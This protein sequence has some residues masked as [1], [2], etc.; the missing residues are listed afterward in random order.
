MSSDVN[1]ALTTFILEADELLSETEQLLIDNE[2][3]ANYGQIDWLHEVFRAVHTIKGSAGLFGLDDLVDFSHLLESLL[4]RL[5]ELDIEVDSTIV[6]LLIDATDVLQLHVDNIDPQNSSHSTPKEI[7][8]KTSALSDQILKYLP[9]LA[10]DFDDKKHREQVQK[11]DSSP[12]SLGIWHISFHPDPDVY[13]DGFDPLSFVRFLATLGEIQSVHIIDD[14]INS[15][16]TFDPEKCYLG[17]EVRLQAAVNRQAILDAFEFILNDA[18]LVIV[19]PDSQVSHYI[20]LIHH[21]PA[22]KQRLGEILVQVGALSQ[23]E[24]ELGLNMQKN[25]GTSQPPAPLLGSVLEE[26]QRISPDV[27]NAAINKQT[28]PVAIAKTLRVEAEKLDQLID[29]VGEMV[30]TGA[31]T[32]LLAHETGD[33]TL[34]EAMAQLERLVES[35]RDSSLQLRMVQIGDTFKKYKRVVRDIASELDKDVDLVITGADT[36]LDKTFV[37][38]LSDPLTH[39]MRNAMDHGIESKEERLAAGKSPKGMIR[40]NAY[41]DSGSIVIEVSDDGRGLDES[42][43]LSTAKAKGLIDSAS[44]TP[45]VDIQ[46]LIFEP[47]FSTKETVSDLSGRGVGMDVVKRNI[48]LLR[49]TIELDTKAGVGS[50]FIIR[51]PL[52]LSIIDGF[53]FQVAGGNYVI[54]LDN[55]VECLEL[56]EVTTETFIRNKQFVDLRDETL[57]FMRLSEWF[58]VPSQSA[59]DQEAL[60]VVQFGS[61]RAGLVVDTLSGEYQTVVKPLGPIFDGLRGVSGATILG[62]GEV[63]II[64]DIFALIQITLSRSEI[65][66]SERFV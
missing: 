62:S 32:N 21:L 11:T 44:D 50:R 37:E 5:R 38:K 33:E 35:I 6:T 4:E 10:V 42:H 66:V 55:V 9:D 18:H 41:H 36:E 61:F 47:G 30:I 1:Q 7:E 53:M 13:Q 57:P 28:P 25:L 43:I 58:G 56:R 23:S 48:E 46:R 34:I 3:T 29:L 39:L 24:L 27:I 16:D 51:L 40:L 12:L 60:V 14:D 63:A 52:T 59:F 49:G 54:P 20:D 64:L 19:P 8:S 2:S 65:D 45:S 22:S 17:F 26:N 15:I 31:R